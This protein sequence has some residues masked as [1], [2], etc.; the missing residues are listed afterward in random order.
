MFGDLLLGARDRFTW[1]HPRDRFPAHFS[2]ER[3]AGAMSR[4]P[5]LGAMARGL[6]AATIATYKAP[7][8]HVAYGCQLRLHLQPLTL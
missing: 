4:S 7:R 6:A 1:N 3:V 8:S 5:L 2:G